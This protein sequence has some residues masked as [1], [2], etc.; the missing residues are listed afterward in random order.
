MKK[1]TFDKQ[2]A[3]LRNGSLPNSIL[4]ISPSL[5]N[6]VMI[7]RPRWKKE[8]NNFVVL[9]EKKFLTIIFKRITCLNYY[10]FG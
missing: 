4:F 9:R 1:N 6:R 8:A 10:P 3:R 7:N 5:L 2:G